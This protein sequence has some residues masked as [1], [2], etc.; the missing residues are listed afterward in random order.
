MDARLGLN[1]TNV[2]NMSTFTDQ[3]NGRV[4]LTSRGIFDWIVIEVCKGSDHQY[5]SYREVK[6][7][8]S[9]ETL[10]PLGPRWNL[11][12]L[13]EGSLPLTTNRGNDSILNKPHLTRTIEDAT[14]SL[15]GIQSYY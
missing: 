13:K 1:V 15:I 2:G 6:E 7:Q 5:I 4:F 10:T 8:L 3:A 12:K 11:A 14:T 9:K